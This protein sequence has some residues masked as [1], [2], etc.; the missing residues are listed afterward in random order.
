MLHWAWLWASET[1]K[2]T[3][4]DTFPLTVPHNS[5]ATSPNPFRQCHSLEPFPSTLP[6]TVWNRHHIQWREA[7]AYKGREHLGVMDGHCTDCSE[8]FTGIHYIQENLP[9]CILHVCEVSCVLITLHWDSEKHAP[10]TWFPHRCAGGEYKPWRP[11]M[12]PLY[13]STQSQLFTKFF[14]SF[15]EKHQ[16]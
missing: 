13:S 16:Q 8:G 2:P 5:K 3:S 11:Q 14:A 4:S 12:R 6:Y 9:N 7:G 1:P 10:F 15:C